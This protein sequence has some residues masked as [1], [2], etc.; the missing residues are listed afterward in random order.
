MV[1]SVVLRASEKICVCPPATQFSCHKTHRCTSFVAVY[2]HYVP[3]KDGQ[4]A[5]QL[6][7][8]LRLPPNSRT[9]VSVQFERAL[10][11]WTEYPPDANHGWVRWT[12]RTPTFSQQLE[13][14]SGSSEYCGLS[15]F[16]LFVQNVQRSWHVVTCPCLSGFTWTRRCWAQC[17]LA[18]PSVATTSRA[19]HTAPPSPPGITTQLI[20]IYG[21][22]DF[23]FCAPSR[24]WWT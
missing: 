2:K 3:G 14:F 1:L 12:W 15:Y 18:T 19:L 8:V 24:W 23:A 7:L 5:Y 16:E 22:C 9:K 21:Q 10:L 6:E 4:R 13:C 11:K 20:R 17:C